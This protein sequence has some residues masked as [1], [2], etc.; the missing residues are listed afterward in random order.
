MS[1]T[2]SAAVARRLILSTQQTRYRGSG[3]YSEKS[4]RQHGTTVP[5][6]Q[7]E[8]EAADWDSFFRFF[9]DHLVKD[10]LA[11]KAV[12][13]FGSGYGGRTVEYKLCGAAQVAG[14]EPFENMVAL[15]N[16]YAAHRGVTGVE[17]RACG[18]Q[19]IPYP[20]N[21]FDVVIS[22]DVLEHVEDP[23]IAMCEIRRV[24]RPGGLSVNVFPVYFGARSH[25]LDYVST[26]PGLHWLFSARALV[27]A[28]NSILTERGDSG[29]LQPEPRRSFDGAHDAL[30]QL[31]GL[32]SR[33]LA[34]LF[35]EFAI[36]SLQRH[37]LH[38]WEP[39]RGRIA[40]AIARSALPDALKDAATS[41]IA[42]ILQKPGA[43]A[44]AVSTLTDAAPIVPVPLLDWTLSHPARLLS[45]TI[46]MR[47]AVPSGQ[48]YL[49]ISPI[50]R[51]PRGG[52]VAATGV[53][54][55]GGITLGLLDRHDHFATQVAVPSGTF[56]KFVDAPADGQYRI[57]IAS[58][59]SGWRGRLDA[60]LSAIGLAG[61]D[62]VAHRVR[63]EITEIVSLEPDAWDA[64]Y[65][66]ARRNGQGLRIKGKPTS[67]SAYAARSAQYR[68]AKGTL[69][70]VAGTV[71]RGGI[72]LGLVDHND[73]WS[74]TALI[75]EGNFRNAIEAPD[76]GIYRIVIVNNLTG[77]QSVND[78]DVREVGVVRLEPASYRVNPVLVREITPFPRDDWAV[79]RP[80]RRQGPGFHLTGTPSAAVVYAAESPWFLLSKGALVAVAG[81]TREGRIMLGLLDRNLTWA[82]TMLIGT[83][84][85]RTAIEVPSDGEYRVI[86]TN[87]FAAGHT[88]TDV[89]INEVGFGKR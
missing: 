35:A 83:S 69:V 39:G 8:S 26:V 71:H 7:A 46:T 41:S 3:E 10:A 13:D 11:G 52:R 19:E 29:A 88:R 74:A 58:N 70:A 64:I 61:L 68:F 79:H 77:R 25:H 56:Q 44:A 62:P 86:L 57:V 31:N 22:Y 59:V 47:G 75:G 14:I 21:S 84:T 54:R 87:D 38:W 43:A 48:A 33:H 9:P 17:F 80:A 78:V 89:V 16:R 40:K 73:H 15:S 4:S 66:P 60:E 32:S 24:L 72:A 76:E 53:V 28:V 30:P 65:P 50:F 51:L 27:T 23:R 63:G 55:R 82:A 1:Q 85:F 67:P 45:D 18:H 12:L 20:D 81:T 42:C 5:F 36:V 49:A 34:E 37:A 6:P 2:I